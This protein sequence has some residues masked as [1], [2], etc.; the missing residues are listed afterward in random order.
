MANIIKV[1]AHWGEPVEIDGKLEPCA[2]T[3]M[4]RD[5]NGRPVSRCRGAACKLTKKGGAWIVLKVEG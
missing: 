3:R 2:C 1:C 4:A 5:Q